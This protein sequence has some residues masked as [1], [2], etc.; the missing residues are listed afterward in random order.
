MRKNNLNSL[1]SFIFLYKSFNCFYYFYFMYYFCFFVKEEIVQKVARKIFATL[2]DQFQKRTFKSMFH[3]R[4]KSHYILS[5]IALE[6]YDINRHS[7]Y[8]KVLL[9]FC[10]IDPMLLVHMW[11]TGQ[12]IKSW[13]L[14]KAYL[15]KCLL[16]RRT[17][18]LHSIGL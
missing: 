1:Y 17:Y 10:E 7:K 4:I 5:T 18:S 15:C 12:N 9:K 14:G 2:M 3:V 6:F 8:Q 16:S 13:L 11:H